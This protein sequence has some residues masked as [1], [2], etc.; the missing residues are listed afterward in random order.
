MDE[1]R[2]TLR[3]RVKHSLSFE[4]RL[5]EAARKAREAAHSLPPGDER[6]RLLRSAR[7]SEAA[8]QLN[9]WMAVPGTKQAKS[10]SD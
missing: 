9:R 3:R 2:T 10:P 1:H 8:A 5:F 6:E 7:E 4:Q